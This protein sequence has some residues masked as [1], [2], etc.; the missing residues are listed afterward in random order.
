MT[1]MFIIWVSLKAAERSKK[2]EAM[3]LHEYQ[4]FRYFNAKLSA[5]SFASLSQF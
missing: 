3:I 5:F 1:N 2:R 4:N